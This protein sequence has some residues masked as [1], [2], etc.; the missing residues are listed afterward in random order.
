MPR[1]F[2]QSAKPV[3]DP[4]MPVDEIMRR[5]PATVR[6]VMRNRML[7]VGCPIGSFHTVAEAC[8]EHGVNEEQFVA[9]L[10]AVIE[11]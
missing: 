11:G 7:C 6:V 4:D 10:M 8:A 1:L 5:W 9:E 3:L 2:F